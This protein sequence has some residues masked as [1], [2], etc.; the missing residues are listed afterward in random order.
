[1]KIVWSIEDLTNDNSLTCNSIVFNDTFCSW[2]IED[3][4]I[5][6]A[7][8]SENLCFRE[9]CFTINQ[10]VITQSGEE[11][12]SLVAG[13]NVNSYTPVAIVDNLI[14]RYDANNIN[15]MFAYIGFSITSATVGNLIT[16]KQKGIVSLS[17]WNLDSGAQYLASTSGNIV[18]QTTTEM[19]RKV[20]GYAASSESMK[21]INDYIP[22]KIQ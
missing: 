10:A 14:Y 6:N 9:I 17:G 12:I 20:I 13:E 21:I 18:K 4:N 22:L 16:I 3:F 8:D 11:N 19:F 2:E 15:H 7:V 1:M 5:D